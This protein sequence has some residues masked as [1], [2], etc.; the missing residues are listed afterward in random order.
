MTKVYGG[1]K[2]MKRNLYNKW[3]LIS[4]RFIVNTQ[5]NLWYLNIYGIYRNIWSYEM[6]GVKNK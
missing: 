4:Y 3:K 5:T 1:K 6:C 2:E